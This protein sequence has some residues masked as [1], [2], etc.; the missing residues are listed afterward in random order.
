[1]KNENFACEFGKTS[2]MFPMK[3]QKND[4][5]WKTTK[6]FPIKKCEFAC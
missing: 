4:I 5:L 3:K 6:D 1:M 2:K